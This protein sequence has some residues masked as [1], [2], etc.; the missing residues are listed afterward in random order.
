MRELLVER[1]AFLR[2]R[3]SDTGLDT[4][5]GDPGHSVELLDAPGARA[6][7]W[8][9]GVADAMDVTML[10]LVDGMGIDVA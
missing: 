2:S 3:V 9:E 5:L 4:V 6:L 8:I 7:G 10:E 1:L